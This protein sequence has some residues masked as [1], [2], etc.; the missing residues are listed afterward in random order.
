VGPDGSL[1][2]AD[3]FSNLVRRVRRDGVLESI[4]GLPEEGPSPDG[5]AALDSPILSPT[6]VAV[7]PDGTVYVAESGRIRRIA[8]DGTITTVAGAEGEPTFGPV[9]SGVPAA[10][11]PIGAVGS[12]A[13]APDGSL[14]FSEQEGRIRKI[15]P[16]GMLDFVAGVDE[17]DEAVGLGEDGPAEV[18]SLADPWGVTVGPDG[19]IYVAENSRV[20]RITPDGTIDTIAGGDPQSCPPAVAASA[21]EARVCIPVAVAVGPDGSVYVGDGSEVYR[22]GPDG[23]F[24]HVAGRP[25]GASFDGDG[26]P[27][28]DATLQ[29]V[30]DLAVAPDGT[31]FILDGCNHRVRRVGVDGVITTV[32]G[33]GPV[34]PEKEYGR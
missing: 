31:L 10:G 8:P 25:G 12:I 32:A 2:V 16:D 23:S 9:R 11:E 15:T 14:V 24:E 27:A 30:A 19:T 33:S 21:L 1:Y 7:A 5:G 4:A 26:G 34:C 3:T 13:L 18:A 20:R 17:Y 22:I 6:D 28:T 29:R